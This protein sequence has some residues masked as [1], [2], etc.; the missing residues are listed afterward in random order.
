[1]KKN[2]EEKQKYINAKE[3]ANKI[4]WFYVHLAAYIVVVVLLSYNL[5][6]VEG[7]YTNNIISLNLSVL[8]AWTVFIIIHGINV[9]K[10]KQIFKQRWEDKK[11]EKYLKE[12]RKDETTFWE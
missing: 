1:M 9:F 7:P 12:N 3:R 8:V 5:Y 6:I 2:H 4:W 10:E 11:T